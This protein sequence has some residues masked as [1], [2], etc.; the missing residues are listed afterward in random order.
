MYAPLLAI[1]TY[2]AIYILAIIFQNEDTLEIL[3]KLL[4][5]EITMEE[6]I[7]ST[8]RLKEERTMQ[9]TFVTEVGSHSWEE[10]LATLP[11]FSTHLDLYRG[12]IKDKELA[13][14]VRC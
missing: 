13:F 8:K 6:A 5:K 14:K 4:E 1:H 11:Q 7:A 12:Q 9:D 3:N 10:A 2:V